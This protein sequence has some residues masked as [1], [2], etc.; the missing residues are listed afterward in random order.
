MELRLNLNESDL[1]LAIAGVK[2][3]LARL[4]QAARFG[5]DCVIS[6]DASSSHEKAYVLDESEVTKGRGLFSPRIRRLLFAWQ[7]EERVRSDGL[8]ELVYGV[9]RLTKGH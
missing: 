7:A 1:R 4:G 8:D 3:I 6:M 5:N 2:K 9:V